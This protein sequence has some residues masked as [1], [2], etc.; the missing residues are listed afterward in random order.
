MA[1][2]YTANK[3]WFEF[4]EGFYRVIASYT[5][6]ELKETR[7][8]EAEF[9]SFKK[10]KDFYFSIVRGADFF[11]WQADGTEVRNRSAPDPW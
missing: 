2:A 1:A 3:V 5:V 7:L 8:A 10:A 6:P 9:R 4:H 11:Y